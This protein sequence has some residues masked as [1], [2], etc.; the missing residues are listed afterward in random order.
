[1]NKFGAQLNGYRQVRI[2]ERN[3]LG[4]NA[5]ADPTARL[6]DSDAPP[7]LGKQTSRMES[8]H[9]RSDDQ[10]LVS[11]GRHNLVRNVVAL[12]GICDAIL[13]SELIRAVN[14][15]PAEAFL[16][17]YGAQNEPPRTEKGWRIWLTQFWTI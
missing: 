7:R 6:H 9:A 10:H 14:E 13:A 12:A 5:T 17:S 3:G 16:Q 11:S 8:R 4:P 2:S 1:V 15:S